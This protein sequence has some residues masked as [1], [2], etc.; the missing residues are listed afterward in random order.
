MTVVEPDL[1][2]EKTGPAA[3]AARHPGHLHAEP[4]QHRRLAAHNVTIYDSL[5]NQ[6]DGG[7]CDVP[8]S[9]FTAQV[10]ESE[11]ATTAVSPV[12]VEGTDYSVS[13]SSA[14]PTARSR[15]RC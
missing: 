2:L 5:P 14:I 6:A 10:F 7:T 1:T 8:P 4:A 12:L 11:P 15:S 13:P 3:G 9:Q